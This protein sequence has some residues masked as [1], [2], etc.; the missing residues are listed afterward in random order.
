MGDR[1]VDVVGVRSVELVRLET[2]RSCND[3][4]GRAARVAVAGD[5][6]VFAV[7]DDG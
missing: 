3:D 5:W 4:T 1:S 2:A 6:M 7:G